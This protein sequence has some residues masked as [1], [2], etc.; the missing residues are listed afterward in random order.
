MN[1]LHLLLNLMLLSIT[2]V[3]FQLGII[4]SNTAIYDFTKKHKFK[5]RIW[6]IVL[7]IVATSYI[8]LISQINHICT[9][10]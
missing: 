5:N 7:M 10:Q 4:W 8:I 1:L 3:F 9:F 6:I 2:F